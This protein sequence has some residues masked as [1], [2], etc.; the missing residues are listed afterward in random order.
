M[1]FTRGFSTIGVQVGLT[2]SY[3]LRPKV[4]SISILGPPVFR[5]VAGRGMLSPRTQ[6]KQILRV[7][8]FIVGG[9]YERK[10]RRT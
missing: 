6:H 4:G 3:T 7:P 2:Y 9:S 1:C 10:A 5:E 8:V